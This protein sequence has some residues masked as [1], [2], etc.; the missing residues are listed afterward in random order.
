[1]SKVT[2]IIPAYNAMEYLPETLENVLQQTLRDFE[3]VIVNDGSSDNIE[4]WFSANVKDPRVR[5]IS[6]ENKGISAARNTG[7]RSTSCPYIAFLDADD[8]W[9]KDK[10]EVQTRV[11]D[12]DR[13]AGLVYTWVAY[14]DSQG[15]PT[16]RVKK[17]CSEGM[18]WSSLL[19]HNIVECGS[20]AL[21]RRE[22][23]EKVGLFDESL[24]SIEDLDMWLR[25][26]KHYPFRAIAKPLVYY[27]QHTSSLSKNLPVMESCYKRVLERTFSEAPPEFSRLKAHSYA[28]VYLCLGWKPIQVKHRNYRES[29]RLIGQ[30]INYDPGV[31]VSK[32]FLKLAISIAVIRCLGSSF[33]SRVLEIAYGVRGRFSGIRDLSFLNNF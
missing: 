29:F 9:E 7:I 25:L 11:L 8:L 17:N 4:S 2:V 26:A 13:K 18:V 6:Q 12:S 10:L 27:R 23:F 20:V 32:D 22:C 19:T 28:S 3:V 5:L 1:M 15:N 14:I 30:A 33:Y 24:R 21:V 16:G 31:I